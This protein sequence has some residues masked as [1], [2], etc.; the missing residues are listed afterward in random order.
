MG[1]N[2]GDHSRRLAVL[3]R[4]RVRDEQTPSG[5]PTQAQAHLAEYPTH[6]LACS[7]A[8]P[9]RA[10]VCPRRGVDSQQPSIGVARSIAPTRALSVAIPV[11]AYI[12]RYS[13]EIIT[14]A[15]RDLRLLTTLRAPRRAASCRTVPGALRADAD[16]LD[17]HRRM[18]GEEL[19]PLVL[20]NQPV[21]RDRDAVDLGRLARSGSAAHFSK[22]SVPG[23][24]VSST[25]CAKVTS[26]LCG[27]CDGGVE[28][29]RAIARQPEDERAEHVNAVMPERRA[30]A[31]TRASPARLNPL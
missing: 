24:G 22:S 26:A 18:R 19:R 16:L 13:L 21:L 5:A 28:R 12:W 8:R 11:F 14:N 9:T 4:L 31:S 27:Q 7:P 10:S 17:R 23:N 15:S 30:A 2:A 1:S 20:R 29:V 3:D 25:N 6:G